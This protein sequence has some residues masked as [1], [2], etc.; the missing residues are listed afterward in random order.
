MTDL[1]PFAIAAAIVV[2]V[3]VILRLRSRV[4]GNSPTSS[5]GSKGRPGTD[6]K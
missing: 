3:A 6:K 5:S 2:A 4:D 1:L